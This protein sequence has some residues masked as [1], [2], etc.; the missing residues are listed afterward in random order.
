MRPFIV[1]LLWFMVPI[2]AAG[3]LLTTHEPTSNPGAY[4]FVVEESTNPWYQSGFVTTDISQPLSGSAELSALKQSVSDSRSR[5]LVQEQQ[6]SD[7]EQCI[8]RITENWQRTYASRS[9][10]K[11]FDEEGNEVS[12]ISFSEVDDS[13]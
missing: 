13:V 4:R 5:T 9:F 6:R 2:I 1:V 8:E 3:F 7:I 12:S 11:E 10:V